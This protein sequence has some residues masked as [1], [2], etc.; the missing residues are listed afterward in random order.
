[1]R[2]RWMELWLSSTYWY[3]L[4]RF[5]SYWVRTC[6]IG[7]TGTVCTTGLPVTHS[8]GDKRFSNYW[9]L[10]LRGLAVHI[11]LISTSFNV[12]LPRVIRVYAQTSKSGR[13][14]GKPEAGAS[15]STSNF[16]LGSCNIKKRRR[17]LQNMSML[18]IT[19][20]FGT[21]FRCRL[22]R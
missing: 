8:S 18:V 11:S 12:V 4:Y 9:T 1:M 6:T 14:Y 19:C 13:S 5:S 3:V 16:N 22:R 17:Q 15:G 20:R 7:T 21:L 2:L 10:I